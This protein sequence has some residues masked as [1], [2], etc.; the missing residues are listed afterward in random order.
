M[1]AV[2]VLATLESHLFSSPRIIMPFA[3]HSFLKV[4]TASVIPSS[5]LTTFSNFLVLLK[6]D[7]HSLQNISLDI[8]VYLEFHLFTSS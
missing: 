6:K 1:Q 7:F 5:V 8:V 3:F 2:E 4:R